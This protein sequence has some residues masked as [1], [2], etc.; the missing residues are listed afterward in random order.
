VG[1]DRSFAVVLL[2]L[3]VATSGF[4]YGG[5]DNNALDLAP[6][7]AGSVMGVI[8]CVSNIPAVVAPYLVGYIT[9]EK[10]GTRLG[11]PYASGPRS[12]SCD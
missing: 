2:T 11:L 10:V 12:I 4:T 9:N 6:Y 1:C 5:K 7:F 3:S 8:N